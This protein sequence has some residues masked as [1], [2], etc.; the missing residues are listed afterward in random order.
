MADLLIFPNYTITEL[1]EVDSTNTYVENLLKNTD[2]P[3]GSVVY[4]KRQ[5]A[6]KG[7]ENNRWESEPDKNLTTTIILKPDFL[8][9]SYQ[10]YLTIILSLS[11][12]DTINHFIQKP[13]S[14]IK[15]PNDIYHKDHKIAGILV[16]NQV[17]GN[18]ISKTIAGLGLNINQ[19]QFKEAPNATSLK[20]ITG[21]DFTIEEVLSKWHTIFA[22]Y[23]M[24]LQTDAGTLMNQ[25]LQ[26]MY[27]RGMEAEYLV[28]GT[29]MFATITGVDG[30]GRLLMETKNGK[31]F[32]CGLKEVIFP[33]FW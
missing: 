16:K 30:Y 31:Q 21:K 27:L 20:L 2:L 7:L 4:T 17:M 32:I 15:W 1:P 6:G 13:E 28:R 18:T 12:S 5:T 33:T 25:Y 23:Y 11:A 3:E 8:D 19:T 9:A 14:C 26:R 24:Q 10:F 29:K 22:E